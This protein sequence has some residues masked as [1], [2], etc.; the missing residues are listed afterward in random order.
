MPESSFFAIGA[1]SNVV[2]IDQEL[3]IA[4]VARWIDQKKIGEFLERVM[5]SLR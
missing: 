3:G 1:G 2:W 4:A 5:A